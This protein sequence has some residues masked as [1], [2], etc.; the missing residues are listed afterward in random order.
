MTIDEDSDCDFWRKDLDPR[1]TDCF[2]QH[3][4]KALWP[5]WPEIKPKS[6]CKNQSRDDRPLDKDI[7]LWLSDLTQTQTDKTD[8]PYWTEHFCSSYQWLWW[9]FWPRTRDTALQKLT[10]T[11]D[12]ETVLWLQDWQRDLFD[13]WLQDCYH[14]QDTKTLASDWQVT[15]HDSDS[16]L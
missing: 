8:W 14:L 2:G 11:M 10:M 1:L 9:P 7:D 6:R 15:T 4:M 13:P 12:N 16:W 5:T 3:S